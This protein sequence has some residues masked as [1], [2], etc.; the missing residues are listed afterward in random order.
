MIAD[1]HHLE[2][3]KWIWA[4]GLTFATATGVLRVM[5]DQHYASDVLT[6]MAAGGLAGWLIPKLHKPEATT[7]ASVTAP[8]KAPATGVAVPLALF[9]G[10]SA[11]LVTIGS[12]GGGPYVG[13][14]LSW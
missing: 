3:R 6:G 13:V 14:H 12:V 11:A 9:A 8:P 4:S 2:N 5:S 7:P 10:R 1:Y